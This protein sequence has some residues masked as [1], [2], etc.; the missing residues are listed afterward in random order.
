[1]DLQTKN[2]RLFDVYPDLAREY[3]QKLHKKKE[4]IPFIQK[5]YSSDKVENIAA[6]RALVSYISTSDI[7]RDNE[8]L[9]PKGISTA[10][11]EKSG[12][13]V[14]WQHR[15][16]EPRDVLGQCLWVKPDASGKS[17]VAKTAFRNSE[18]ADEVYQ[19]Y[20]DDLA[21]QGPILRGWSVGFIPLEWDEG[22]KSGDARRT[23]TKWELLEYSAVSLPCNPSAQTIIG[24]KGIHLSDRLKQDL[25]IETPAPIVEPE[26]TASVTDSSQTAETKVLDSE[27]NPSMQDIFMAIGR[28]LNPPQE[29][30]QEVNGLP[31]PWYSIAEIYPVDFPSGHCMFTEYLPG[32]DIQLSYR[33]DYKYAD[34]RATMMG[35]RAEV[36]IAW[37]AKA[38]PE[39][40]TIGEITVKISGDII[41]VTEKIEEVKAGLSDILRMAAEV[42]AAIPASSVPD[43]KEPDPVD[44]LKAIQEHERFVAIINGL[45]DIRQDIAIPA[46]ALSDITEREVTFADLRAAVAE[47]K[48]TVAA[49]KAPSVTTEPVICGHCKS[50]FEYGARPEMAPGAVSCPNCGLLVNQGGLVVPP[51]SAPAPVDLKAIVKDALMSLDIGAIVRK[52]TALQLAKLKGKVE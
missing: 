1:M 11:F 9:L 20:T 28:A 25:G 29:K 45:A 22:K 3:A 30:P 7:D 10:H 42:K 16:D 31:V 2:L 49:L 37:R 40:K 41:D 34:G 23:F 50:S 4:D 51:K 46:P 15:Y 32:R 43:I 5:F 13:P 39:E 26:V 14:F 8:I 48:A 27:D 18:F 44:A 19:L 21:G 33:Q 12:K 38:V 35:D 6:E 24:Q 36:V 52:E 17:I 47:I